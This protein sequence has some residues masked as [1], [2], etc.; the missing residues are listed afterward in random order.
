M[1][2]TKILFIVLTVITIFSQVP[3]VYYTFK[4]FTKIE[5]KWL[6]ELQA[7]L[8]CGILST[9][10]FAFV[11]IGRKDLALFG[12]AVEVVIN[13]YYYSLHY[14]SRRGNKFDTRKNWIAIFF[15]VL[16]PGMIYI[17]SDILVGLS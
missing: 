9:A 3:H 10:I 1:T 4:S 12:A 7:V 15:G 13:T 6:V 8:F 2:N 14:W 11:L 17:F 16:L 5:Q